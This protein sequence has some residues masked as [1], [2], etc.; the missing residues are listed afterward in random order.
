[1]ADK[2]IT[3]VLSDESLNAY[4]FW[5]KTS[6]IDLSQFKKNPVMLYNHYSNMLPIG[7]WENIRIEDGRLLADANFDE[8]DNNVKEISRK[9]KAGMLR[10]ASIGIEP[11]KTSNNEADL[12]VGQ[13]RSTVLK[14]VLYE[15]SITSFPANRNA[16]KLTDP[17]YLIELLDANFK[18]EKNNK[19]K[20]VLTK[21][22]L[23]ADTT[24][25][26]AVEKIAELQTQLAEMQEAR[27]KVLMKLSEL[28]GGLSEDLKLKVTKLADNDI[29]L[30]LDYLGNLSTTSKETEKTDLRLSKVLEKLSKG[31]APEQTYRELAEN[32]PA[33]L[34]RLHKEDFAT[35]NKLY[36]AEYGKDY[37][38]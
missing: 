35:F 28:K 33:E 38:S 10:G 3:F 11:K 22:N 2:P 18:I 6:G 27:N 13:T 7:K 9:V 5:V 14:S 12:K 25:E 32:N 24:E 36:K 29:D 37:V 20:E 21:L 16:L 8:E 26:K 1:M 15:A 19:M 34:Q 17:N 31:S 23:S 4:G 30:A